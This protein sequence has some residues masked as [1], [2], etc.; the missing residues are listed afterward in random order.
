MRQFVESKDSNHANDEMVNTAEDVHLDSSVLENT[1]AQ[2]E[3]ASQVE[4][5]IQ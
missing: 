2:T 5:K 3:A 1:E 4:F